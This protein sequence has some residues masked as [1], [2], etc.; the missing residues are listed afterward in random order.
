[1]SIGE[2]IRTRHSGTDA[3]GFF[4]QEHIQNLRRLDLS[5]PRDIE[6]G[7]NSLQDIVAPKCEFAVAC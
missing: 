3:D 1:M 4:T 6:P 5:F 2:W 7:M